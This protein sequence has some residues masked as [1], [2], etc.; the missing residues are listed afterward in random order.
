M[1]QINVAEML[2]GLSYD[3]FLSH[4]TDQCKAPQSSM[5]S[6][7]HRLQPAS[8]E[9]EAVHFTCYRPASA[10]IE[11]VRFIGCQPIVT[12]KPIQIWLANSRDEARTTIRRGTLG[13]YQTPSTYE[14]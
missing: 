7:F 3:P 6:Q 2:E 5:I 9:M 14:V 12:C 1:I 10:E 8:A 4:P 11:A 13:A